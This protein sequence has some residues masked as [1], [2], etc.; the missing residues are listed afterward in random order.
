MGSL[1]GDDEEENVDTDDSL[2]P[3]EGINFDNLSEENQQILMELEAAGEVDASADDAKDKDKKKAKKPKKEKPKKEKPKKAPK[4]KKVKKPKEKDNT[5]PLPKKPVMAIVIM[6]A[7]LFGLVMLGT[8]LMGYQ[9]SVSQ[10]KSLLKEQ[11]YVEAYGKLAG[12]TIKEKDMTL[13]QQLETLA[14]VSSEYNSYLVF[15]HAK[16]HD[17]ALDS[18]ICAYG[19]YSRNRDRAIEL[20]C[21][22]DLENMGSDIITA[23]LAEFDMTGPE[24]LELYDIRSRKEY[25]IQLHYKL[26]EL[27][28][29]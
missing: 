7:S 6:V 17:M 14:P 24:A 27:G 12:C 25:T 10:A 1:L 5:P 26:Q 3:K 20:E 4:P 21:L 15:S 18:L 23:L 8:K 19:R 11:R 9:L 2:S 16:K 22:A 29:E 28:L 13:F